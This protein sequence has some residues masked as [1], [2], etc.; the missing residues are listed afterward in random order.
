MTVSR[1]RVAKVLEDAA[2][3]MEE[4]GLHKGTYVKGWESQGDAPTRR[5][6]RAIGGP[7]CVYGALIASTGRVDT[8]SAREAA[9]ALVEDLGGDDLVD[10]NDHPNRRKAY[11]VKKLRKVAANIKEGIK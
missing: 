9:Q 5:Q 10:W 8:P 6:I 2:D 11:V 3:Y 7:V 1:M 4:H